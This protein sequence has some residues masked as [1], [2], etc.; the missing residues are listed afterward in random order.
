MKSFN[1]SVTQRCLCRLPLPPSLPP[2]SASP[3]PCLCILRGVN[4]RGVGVGGS[5][6]VHGY[7]MCLGGYATWLPSVRMSHG[8]LLS[9]FPPL[10]FCIT[11]DLL[12]LRQSFISFP[13]LLCI[14]SH[15][16]HA[17]SPSYPSSLGTNKD[18]QASHPMESGARE[19]LGRLF[20]LHHFK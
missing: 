15:L 4:S 20:V 7:R 11:P 8:A 10:A 14:L 17:C 12:P 9:H 18:V 2:P 1:I 3:S 16:L 19:H 5:A 13:F 6:M